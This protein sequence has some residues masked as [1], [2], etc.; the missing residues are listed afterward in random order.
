MSHCT[1]SYYYLKPDGTKLRSTEDFIG[2]GSHALVIRQGDYALKIPKVTVTV[3]EKLST[4]DLEDEEY[5][6]DLHR[7][8][9]ELEKDVYRRANDCSGIAKCIDISDR[10]ILL[11]LYD[12]GNLEDYIKHRPEI[13]AIRKRKWMYS[14]IQTLHHLHC[15]KVLVSDLALRNLLLDGQTRL[16]MV[17][18]GEAAVFPIDADLDTVNDGGMTAQVDIFQLGCL[19]YSI[20][21]CTKFERDLA[22]EGFLR[23]CLSDMHPLDDVHLAGLIQKC[24]SGQYINMHQLYQEIKGIRGWVWGFWYWSSDVIRLRN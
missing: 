21:A 22:C 1:A 23:P 20:A 3:S 24:W 18:F 8:C 11:E 15:L 10:G 16:K 9:L 12:Q 5:I 19:L 7:K 4:N 2:N 6:N 17:D 14:L 13:S